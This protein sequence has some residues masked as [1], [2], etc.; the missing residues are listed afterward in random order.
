MLDSIIAP[1][2]HASSVFNKPS[3]HI[4][5]EPGESILTAHWLQTTTN[6][7]ARNDYGDLLAVARVQDRCRF[8]MVDLSHRVPYS[9][10]MYQWFAYT[11]APHAV[12]SLG[13]PLFIAYIMAAQHGYARDLAIER[14]QQLCAAHD[15]HMAFFETR[16]AGLAWLQHQQEYDPA[17]G[18]GP[19]PL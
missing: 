4:L 15:L 19:A 6:E 7:S 5:H 1:L 3:F 18:E 12:R 9:K 13:H 14:L 11:F 16:H 17:P 2:S 10:D 8:W